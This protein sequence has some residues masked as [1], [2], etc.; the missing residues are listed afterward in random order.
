MTLR[1]IKV[2]YPWLDTPVKGAFFVPTLKL[3][4]VKETGLKAALHHGIIGKAEFG[5]FGGKIGVRFTRVR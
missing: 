1:K 5:T 3:Q 4:D 2:H